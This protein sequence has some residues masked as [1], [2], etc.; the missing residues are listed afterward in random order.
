MTWSLQP[1]NFQAVPPE[2]VLVPL[3]AG[4]VSASKLYRFLVTKLEMTMI[5]SRF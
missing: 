4:G 2:E 3:T 1:D 5:G